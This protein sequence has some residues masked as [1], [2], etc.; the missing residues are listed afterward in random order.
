VDL[1]KQGWG[2]F[3]NA[4]A[5][6]VA[7]VH[8]DVRRPARV[9]IG[10][11]DGHAVWVNGKLGEKRPTTRGFTFDDDFCDVELVPGWNRVL[12]KVHNGAG[13]W[14]FLARI[15]DPA[16]RPLDLRA[17]T[18]NHER[19]PREPKR[20]WSQLV[21]DEFKS[22]NKRRW[23]QAVGKFDTQNSRLRALGTAKLGLWQ[24]FVV[25][26]DKPKDGPA[27]IAWLREPE[28]ARTD[29]LRIELEVV[30]P[31]AKF[32]VT[33]DGENENDGQSGHT[34]VFEPHKEKL[35]CSW[36]RYDRMLYLNEGEKYEPG[37]VVR[38][39]I[40]RV[41]TKWTVKA[42]GAVLFDGVDAP[43][44]PAAGIGL[45]TWGKTP[46]FEALRIWRGVSK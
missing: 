3:K 16:G 13:E 37:E 38:L 18:E 4:C 9:W 36:Y 12:V 42:N 28:L 2:Y 39:E 19:K 35:K 10:S 26:P 5:F 17:S 33:V 31:V 41:G 6:A 7:Y 29:D 40:E 44:L 27:N 20:S 32:G 11:D 23:R 24:R 22:L 8:S 25:D 45:L 21:G 14:G 1:K 15:T 43:R 46:Q 34:L 30:A